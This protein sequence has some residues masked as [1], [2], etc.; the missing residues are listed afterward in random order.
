M[1]TTR[2]LR[3]SRHLLPAI[4][5][6]SLLGLLVPVS[7]VEADSVVSFADPNLEWAVRLNLL[8]FSGAIYESDLVGLTSLVAFS[9]GITNLAG[10]EY[11]TSLTNL[12]LLSNQISD[13]TPL[14]GLTNLTLMDLRNNQISDLTPLSG[15]TNLTS[16][17]LGNNQTSDLTPL[18]GLPSLTSLDLSDNQISD[19]TPLGSLTDLTWLNLGENQ[20]D[21]V[22]PLT[23]LTSLTWLDLSHNQIGDVDPLA[24]L[25]DLMLLNLQDTQISDLTPLA[26]LDNLTSL[27]LNDNQ[28]SNI[29]PL[30]SLNGLL[31]LSLSKNQI[32]NITPL[33]GLVLLTSL[34]LDDNQISDITPL[35]GL[36]LL[37]LLGLDD[38]QISDITPLDGLTLLT[39]L[40]LDDNQVSDIEPLVNN[41][42]MESGDT[43]YLRG[44]PLSSTSM[45][46]WIPALQGRGVTVYWDAP[47]NQSPVQ[48]SNVSPA[49][50]ATGVIPTPTLV[51]TDYYDPDNDDHEASQWQ[52]TE[53]AG[54]YGT[55]V[56]DSG[57]DNAH[58]T[59]ITAPT[60]DYSTT[61][62]WRVRYRDSRLS[63]PS[64]WSE[65]TSF[66][67]APTSPLVTTNDPSS[68]ATNSARLNGELT[69]L[70]TAGSVM[71]S[72]IWGTSPGSYPNETASEFRTSTGTFHSDLPDLDPGTTHYYRAKAVGNGTSYGDEKSFSTATTYPGV[73]TDDASNLATTSATLNGELGNLGTATSVTV[74]FEWKVSGGSYAPIAVEV[75]DSIGAFSA[76]LTGLT[77]GT[78]YYFKAKAVGDG[79]SYGAEKSF[80]T[81]PPSPTVTTN[82]A[83]SIT[84]NSA[85]LNGDLISLGTAG[86][87]NVSF[88]WK[89]VGGSYT[90]IAAGAKGSIGPFSADL[91]GLTPGTTYYFR[92]KALGD[93]TSYG[94][95]KTFTT[96]TTSPAVITND[97]DNLAP[98]SATLNGYL[99]DLGTTTSVTVSFEWGLTTSHG[100]ETTLEFRGASGNFSFN[101]T[102]LVSGTTYY[103]RAKAVGDGTSY[104]DE[105]TF[106]TLPPSPLVTTNDPSNV[107]TKSARLNGDLTWLGTASSVTVSFEWGIS[108]KSYTN[109]TAGQ[110]MTGTGAF[111]F[112]LSGLSPGTTYYFRAK[113]VGNGTGYGDEKSFTTGRKAVV[114]GID[115][116]SGK[117]GER[118]TVT[119]AG[120]NFDGASKVNFGSGITV[121]EFNV[122]SGGEIIADIT[123]DDDA[124]VGARDVSVT[125]EWGTGTKQDGFG[126]VG[127]RGM[128]SWI[129]V[130]VGASGVLALGVLAYFVA[131]GR[132]TKPTP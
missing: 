102:G 16:L 80:S 75:K 63:P 46:T 100:N 52:I 58:L 44:N 70:G 79:T 18:A 3:L 19:I 83:S 91:T 56:F 88:E 74:S 116:S 35:D 42:G 55:T 37:T 112:D 1:T 98:T 10:L 95:E 86:S 94:D 62:Y 125:T 111:Y 13:L 61:Y 17:D 69:W 47:G 65:E 97:A 29:S 43:V 45:Y 14:S 40:N 41:T 12:I 118:L 99:D 57:W 90:P 114:E 126:V 77:P 26:E 60:L 4:L 96:A 89:G 38:N 93:G 21:D 66:T 50:A 67:A 110:D 20:F 121:K 51:A 82:D 106:T 113:A 27:N 5:L 78:T 123:I 73:T 119:I 104:G 32:S 107:G 6:I 54:D 105:K 31:T 76:D 7:V 127:G 22:A 131:R 85:R 103:F 48:P 81:F 33:D 53:T 23:S 109:E 71:V 11:C 115:P 92:A 36:I 124:K 132:T 39:S 117:R 30:A 8:K 59:S 9:F 129:W 101:L 28:I 34:N 108:S 72:F 84:I 24:E 68:I 15:L 128:Y 87:V 25:T 49:D 130:A 120:A 122:V 64:F 2:F